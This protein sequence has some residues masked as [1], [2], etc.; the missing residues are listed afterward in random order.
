MN[1]GLPIIVILIGILVTSSIYAWL[2]YF[3]A[4]RYRKI[5]P[6]QLMIIYGRKNINPVTGSEKH[7]SALG[8]KISFF[9]VR[10]I[11]L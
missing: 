11:R 3:W 7:L 9:D 6:N 2:I 8:M 4:G 1:E 5:P 10:K